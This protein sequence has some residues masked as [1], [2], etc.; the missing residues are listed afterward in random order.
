MHSTHLF[1][2][3]VANSIQ[4]EQRAGAP[5]RPLS[6]ILSR[7]RSPT[8]RTRPYVTLPICLLV[9]GFQPVPAPDM[10]H[11][12][13]GTYARACGR[14][15]HLTSL[16]NTKSCTDTRLARILVHWRRR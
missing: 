12:A 14:R 2:G 5:S 15:A 9:S 1:K 4:Q 7:S 11:L 8:S 16:A 10:C 13:R 6:T 3:S